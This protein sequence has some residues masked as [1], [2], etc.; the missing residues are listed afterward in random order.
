MCD[1]VYSTTR[2]IPIEKRNRKRMKNER[3]TRENREKRYVYAY[4]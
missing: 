2:S 3:I 4:I 1:F